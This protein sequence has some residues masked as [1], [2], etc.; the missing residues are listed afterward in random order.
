MNRTPEPK[1]KTIDHAVAK[2]VLGVL[3][4]G[5]DASQRFLSPCGQYHL[6]LC[7]HCNTVTWVG[8]EVVSFTCQACSALLAHASYHCGECHAT[9][10]DPHKPHC[11]RQGAVS[12][13]SCYPYVYN[14][15]LLD[16]VKK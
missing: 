13:E 5:W 7:D 16:A 3:K 10:G 15:D 4:L 9:L 8:L 12:S 14:H 11:E 6:A 1:V 2:K